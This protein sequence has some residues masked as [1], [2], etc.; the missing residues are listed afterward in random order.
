MSNIYSNTLKESLTK[1][2]YLLDFILR[3]ES[4]SRSKTEAWWLEISLGKM[5]TYILILFPELFVLYSKSAF[6]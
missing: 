1:V 6:M 4:M 3:D 5:K 2:T